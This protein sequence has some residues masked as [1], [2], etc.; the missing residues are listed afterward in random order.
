MIERDG[1]S[2]R[3]FIWVVKSRKAVNRQKEKDGDWENRKAKEQINKERQI[4]G[5]LRIKK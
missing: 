1:N 4:R 2:F 5:M 3:G